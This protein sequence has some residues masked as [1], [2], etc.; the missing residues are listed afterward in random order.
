MVGALLVKNGEIIGEGFHYKKGEGHAEVNAIKNATADILGATLYCSLEPCCHTN[1][2]TPPCTDLIIKSGISKVVVAT[3]DPNPSVAGK[4]LK[5]LKKSGIK[6][7]SGF[8][9]EEAIELNKVFFK[10]VQSTLPYIHLKVAITMDGRIATAQGDSKWIST[11]A[12]RS[13]VHEYRHQY[14]GVM[15]GRN[16]LN[17]D[18]PKLTARFGAR[19]IKSPRAI[20]IGDPTNFNKDSL[21]LKNPSNLLLLNTGDDK[22]LPIEAENSYSIER[23]DGLED[24]MKW[25]KTK[26][27]ESILVEGGSKVISSFIEQDLYDELT[28]FICPKI[29]GNGSSFFNSSR[30]NLM[31]NALTLEGVAEQSS[32]GDIIYKVRKNVYRAS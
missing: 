8:C 16:T 15:I 11:Q 32:G 29:I 28:L 12:S 30:A 17:L 18:N 13:L 2:L 5:A 1:K 25:L 27:V 19:L 31:K 6:T 24:G 9:E 22:N 10:S 7:F 3:L 23:S 14:D 21:L 26:G 20:I 4:G